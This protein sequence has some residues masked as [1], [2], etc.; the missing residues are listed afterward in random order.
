MKF[1][2]KLKIQTIGISIAIA[3]LLMSMA[4]FFRLGFLSETYLLE[5]DI[6]NI[7]EFFVAWIGLFIL[8]QMLLENSRGLKLLSLQGKA[9]ELTL[10]EKEQKKKELKN[11]SNEELWKRVGVDDK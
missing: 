2:T 3:G 7:P 10:K 4:I 5:R 1:K 9:R 11:M 8:C 6:F